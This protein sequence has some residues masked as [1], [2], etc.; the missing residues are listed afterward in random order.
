MATR[1]KTV[2]RLRPAAR[3][4]RTFTAELV[5]VEGM[6]SGLAFQY[7]DVTTG[8]VD[9]YIE[10]TVSLGPLFA[11]AGYRYVTFQF[12]QEDDPDAYEVDLAIDGFYITVGARF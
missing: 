9:A 5:R 6:L 10:A 12:Q 1:A 7:G 8:F 3:S 4:E 11:G 2:T